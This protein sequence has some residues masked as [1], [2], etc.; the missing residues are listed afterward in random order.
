[1]RL[2][3]VATRRF[4][5][6]R[7]VAVT[8]GVRDGV[9]AFMTKPAVQKVA[10]SARGLAQRFSPT[11]ASRQG[12]RAFASVVREFAQPDEVALNL[13]VHPLRSGIQERVP[14]GFLSLGEA[15][16]KPAEAP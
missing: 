16:A 15:A 1:M 13:H 4:Q 11:R 12:R 2:P 5:S 7:G 8:V 3:A 9:N 6:I 14:F 10:T